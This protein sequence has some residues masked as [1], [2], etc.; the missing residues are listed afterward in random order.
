MQTR[1][2][3]INLMLFKRIIDLEYLSGLRAFPYI[4]IQPNLVTVKL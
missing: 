2:V 4:T 1:S 3:C